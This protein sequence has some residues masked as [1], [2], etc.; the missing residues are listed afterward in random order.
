MKA[1]QGLVLPHPWAMIDH[2]WPTLVSGPRQRHPLCKLEIHGPSSRA[3]RAGF[4][5]P[6]TTCSS[7]FSCDSGA[8]EK[9]CQDE[10]WDC[11]DC[12]GRLHCLLT[13]TL[14]CTGNYS[15]Q[16]S[17]TL[18]KVT[19]KRF[20]PSDLSWNVGWDAGSF[21]KVSRNSKSIETVNSILNIGFSNYGQDRKT[22]QWNA[23]TSKAEKTLT[24][25]VPAVYLVLQE[26][27]SNVKQIAL[28]LKAF[29]CSSCL[30]F[31]NG[32]YGRKDEWFMSAQCKTSNN[33]LKQCFIAWGNGVKQTTFMVIFT[34]RKCIDFWQGKKI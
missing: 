17:T 13:R 1:T 16:N 12:C 8:L 24:A 20:P 32:K 14:S 4:A 25:K 15:P 5:A 19:T 21:E 3:A 7:C 30:Q 22:I 29:F 6:S 33:I 2:Q 27:Q 26:W 31:S 23:H 10:P 9:E 28:C 18:L 11:M 34:E